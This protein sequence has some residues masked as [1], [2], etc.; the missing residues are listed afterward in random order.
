MADPNQPLYASRSNSIAIELL[1]P[2]TPHNQT[3]SPGVTYLAL[4][5]THPPAEFKINLEQYKFTRYLRFLRYEEGEKNGAIPLAKEALQEII[6]TILEGIPALQAEASASSEWLHLRLIMTPRELAMLPFEFAL[7]PTGFQGARE[8]DLLVNSQRLTTLTRE[9]RQVA[10][11]TYNW[12]A[13]PRVLFVWAAPGKFP[14]PPHADHEALLKTALMPWTCPD[15]DQ[16]EPQPNYKPQLRVLNKVTFDALQ[17]A[18][19]TAVKE[20]APYTHVHIL[21]HGTEIPDENGPRFA[22]AFHVG[23]PIPGDDFAVQE[24]IDG[25]RLREALVV[26]QDNRF[27]SPA[28]VTIAACDGGNEGTNLSPGGSLAYALHQSGVPYVLASQFPLSMPGSV[29]MV[30]ELYPRLLRGEDPRTTLYYV[31][32]SLWNNAAVHDWAS[33]VA[34]ARFPD[35]FEDQL[36]D[37]QLRIAFDLMKAANAWTDHL[38]RHSIYSEAIYADVATRLKQ[39]IAELENLLPTDANAVKNRGRLAEHFGLLGSAYKRL[40]EHLYRQSLQNVAQPDALQKQGRNDLKKARHFYERGHNASLASHWNA[41][42]YLSL[43]AIFKGT[44]EPEQD[45]WHTA[46][47]AAENE[48]G[49]TTN[50]DRVWPLGSLAELYL[51]KPLLGA[52]HDTEPEKT[53]ALEKAGYYLQQLNELNVSYAS[54][55]TTRQFERYVTWWANTVSSAATVPLRDMATHLLQLLPASAD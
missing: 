13:K 26:V 38:L 29:Q 18:I 20:K 21:A 32:H 6:T 50:E 2:G 53:Q 44:L 49:Q 9:I 52:G 7:T 34:Y 55:S 36:K 22:L 46:R 28:V 3:L 43:T 47:F 14:E 41:V 27:Y 51:L 30:Q 37:N 8:K 31:R 42:Q 45:R 5:G 12:P 40:A 11:R 24:S 4:C 10:P 23:K 33:L 39:A 17:E 25:A 16:A 15:A 19:L 48:L 54:E 1:R 35:D